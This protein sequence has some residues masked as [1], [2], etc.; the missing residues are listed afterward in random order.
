MFIINNYYNTFF[1]PQ[2]LSTL[3][4]VDQMHGSIW[5]T[6]IHWVIFS[7]SDSRLII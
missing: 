6:A 2:I 4:L 7:Y 1:S 5:S 3:V